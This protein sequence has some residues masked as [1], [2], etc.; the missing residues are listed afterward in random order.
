MLKYNREPD[1][2]YIGKEN[3]KKI[4]LQRVVAKQKIKRE[5]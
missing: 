5:G 4:L 2:Y 1:A 3:E